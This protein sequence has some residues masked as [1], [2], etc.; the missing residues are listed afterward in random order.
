MYNIINKQFRE[1]VKMKRF[2]IKNNS[3][4]VKLEYLVIASFNLVYF[5][6]EYG[7]NDK[8]KTCNYVEARYRLNSKIDTIASK[9]NFDKIEWNVKDNENFYPV[10][11]EYIRTI[12]DKNKLSFKD[13]RCYDYLE[14]AVYNI[15]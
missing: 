1:V 13:V 5:L 6:N 14:E 7:E 2:F 3:E 8:F 4:T 10:F 12:L 9:I 11:K 15:L